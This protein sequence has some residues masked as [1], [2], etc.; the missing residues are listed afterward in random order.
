[1]TP[2]TPTVNLPLLG[3]QAGFRR[4]SVAEY[5]KL[6]DIGLLTEDDNLELIEG[7]L[8]QKM[9]HNPPHDGTIDLVRETLKQLLPGGWMLRIQQAITL[10][11]SEPEPDFA[12]VRG[13]R[14]TFLARHPGPADVGLVIEVADSTLAGDRADKGR[15]YAR[16][17]IACYW[18]VNLIGRQVEVYTSP[19]G[20]VA[21]PV[22]S[23]RDDYRPGDLLPLTLDGAA[24]ASPAVHELLP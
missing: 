2:P 8:V 11:D 9:P 1:M 12:V 21:S 16:A 4:F 6:I 13:D 5:H 19:S 20:P 15:I 7:Y 23:R 3:I 18:I 22:F 17:A 24:V 14:R 10:S